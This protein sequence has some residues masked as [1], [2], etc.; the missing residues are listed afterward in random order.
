MLYILPFTI[1][2]SKIN[3]IVNFVFTKKNFFQS[4]T[5]KLKRLSNKERSEIQL[6]DKLKEI[7]I[8]TILGDAYIRKFSNKSNTRIVF[9]QG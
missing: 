7:L 1:N 3:T 6:E 9:R 4:S 8:D 2:F 5:F